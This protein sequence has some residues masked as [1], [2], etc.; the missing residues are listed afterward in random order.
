MSKTATP[1]LAERIYHRVAR[2]CID[3]YKASLRLDDPHAW[4]DAEEA[5]I[6]AIERCEFEVREGLYDEMLRAS[7]R[8]GAPS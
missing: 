8:Q 6:E 4:L 3:R 2:V 7:V 1:T 5:A